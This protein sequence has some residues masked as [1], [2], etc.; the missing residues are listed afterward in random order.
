MT[1]A[2]QIAHPWHALITRFLDVGRKYT[3]LFKTKVLKKDLGNVQLFIMDCS[4]SLKGSVI[5][6]D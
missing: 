1:L 4:L 3:F 2:L 5:I 6:G